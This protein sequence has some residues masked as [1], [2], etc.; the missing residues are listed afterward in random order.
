[1]CA[2]VEVNRFV[3]RRLSLKLSGAM[4]FIYSKIRATK[5]HRLFMWNESRSKEIGFIYHHVCVKKS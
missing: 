3:A 1:V 2:V 5:F 4:R